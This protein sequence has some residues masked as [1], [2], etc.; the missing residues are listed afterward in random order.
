MPLNLHNYPLRRNRRGKSAC[1]LCRKKKVKCDGNSPCSTCV[2]YKNQR[3]D[4]MTNRL[5]PNRNFQGLK[6]IKP[7]SVSEKSKIVHG[8]NPLPLNETNIISEYSEFPANTN[9][10]YHSK[11]PYDL[12]QESIRIFEDGK[13]VGSSGYNRQY[14]GP[15]SWFTL[16][17]LDEYTLPFVRYIEAHKKDFKT[18]NEDLD[19]YS[20]EGHNF[21]DI[22]TQTRVGSLSLQ[23]R[24]G[25]QAKTNRYPVF[26][27]DFQDDDLIERIKGILPSRKL[28][29]KLLDYFFLKIFPFFPL[30]DEFDFRKQL[31]EIIGEKDSTNERLKGLTIRNNVDIAVIGLLLIFLRLTYLAL[32][33]NLGDNKNKDI[34]SNL[35]KEFLISNVIGMDSFKVAQFC[36]GLFNYKQC[37]DVQVLQLALYIR[38]YYT[39]APEE[40]DGLDNRLSRTL[41]SIIVQ[42]AYSLGFSRDPS[43]MSYKFSNPRLSNLSRK[44]WHFIMCLDYNNSILVG[45]PLMTSIIPSDTKLPYYNQG[46]ENSIDKSL[47]REIIHVFKNIQRRLE[48]L[49]IAFDVVFNVQEGMNINQLLRSLVYLESYLQEGDIISKNQSGIIHLVTLEDMI[50]LNGM[51]DIKFLMSSI[52]FKMYIHYEK[53]KNDGLV[54]FYAKKLLK[55]SVIDQF[56][57]YLKALDGINALDEV[58]LFYVI[59]SL[60]RLSQ[61]FFFCLSFILIR[62]KYFEFK[63]KIAEGNDSNMVKKDRLYLR[64]QTI[65]SLLQKCTQWML[66]WLK[67]LSMKYYIAW[68]LYKVH[69]HT[70]SVMLSESFYSESKASIL[71]LWD[72]FDEK[73]IDEMIELLNPLFNETELHQEPSF[74]QNTLNTEELS[75]QA[76]FTKNDTTNSTPTTTTDFDEFWLQMMSMKND[77]V[78]SD[79]NNYFDIFDPLT[80][81][82]LE[83]D[84]VLDPDFN[85]N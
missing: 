74:Q 81:T 36:F 25:A 37:N 50:E 79:Y 34:D 71:N 22:N 21:Q 18:I 30:V 64:A 11:I 41:N 67:K 51:L 55:I 83:S 4:L 45:D 35:E 63:M 29:W 38:V 52:Y 24:T 26:A 73:A 19:I 1:S 8:A 39:Y 61:K 2:K 57:Y 44:I 14:F 3:C 5:P 68:R 28:S 80:N 13:V 66:D 31:A 85:L 76:P 82:A 9:L 69:S 15:L 6:P 72:P 10:G 77:P 53:K 16:L 40:G 70:L 33:S 46:N 20:K 47:E 12:P 32:T 56:P 62:V 84:P 23:K 17:F 58:S 65:I 43:N 27:Y 7:Y 54:R 78:N 42:M 59:P 75:Y 48:L 49:K 60:I